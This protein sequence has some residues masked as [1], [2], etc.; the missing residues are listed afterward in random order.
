MSQLTKEQIT[1]VVDAIYNAIPNENYTLAYFGA[2]IEDNDL[3][4]LFTEDEMQTFH[5]CQLTYQKEEI[6]EEEDDCDCAED[7]TCNVCDAD[8]QDN[9]I[10]YDVHRNYPWSS[11]SWYEDEDT[12]EDGLREE[13]ERVVR[14]V[15][16]D[17]E[18][19]KDGEGE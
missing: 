7:E 1:E 18:E 11:G 9:S 17:E 12:L 19:V 14:L 3:Q 16:G 15:I 8:E 2:A 6:D 4:H 5:E 10:T 13:V